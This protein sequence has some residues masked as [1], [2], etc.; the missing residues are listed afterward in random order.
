MAVNIF[1][2]EEKQ[3]AVSPWQEV[4]L[5]QEQHVI[6]NNPHRKEN[7]SLKFKISEMVLLVN[8]SH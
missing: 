1:F 6:A 2:C 8:L 7:V 3:I 5:L 4:L